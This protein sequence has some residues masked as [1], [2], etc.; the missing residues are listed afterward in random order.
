[1]THSTG[2]GTKFSSC[3]LV[4]LVTLQELAEGV[5]SYDR[6]IH[7]SAWDCQRQALVFLLRDAVPASIGTSSRVDCLKAIWFDTC[8][9]GGCNRSSTI[10]VQLSGQTWA[11]GGGSVVKHEHNTLMDMRTDLTAQRYHTPA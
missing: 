10:V 6:F 7:F 8:V 2:Q 11:S 9:E 5:R 3:K 1:M 4:F